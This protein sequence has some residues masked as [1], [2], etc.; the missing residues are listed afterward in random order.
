MIRA[1][2]IKQTH[3]STEKTLSCHLVFEL[4]MDKPEDPVSF[5]GDRQPGCETCITNNVQ[6][7]L[8]PTVDLILKDMCGTG[9]TMPSGFDLILDL[10]GAA[11]VDQTDR[12]LVV[13]V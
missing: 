8:L 13:T 7:D 10:L 9:K 11:T 4:A 3:T 2:R 1:V 12:P 6:T 5:W